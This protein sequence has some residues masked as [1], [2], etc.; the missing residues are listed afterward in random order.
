MIIWLIGMSGAGKTTIGQILYQKI[1]TEH[2]NT[3]FLDGD[4]LRDVWGDHLG[5]DMEGRRK[6]AER[7]T[8]LCLMLDRQ[9]IH[10]VAAIL[11]IFPEERRKNRDIFS[12]YFEVFIDTPMEELVRRD[13]KRL[14]AR[15]AAG[16]I[17]D[18]VGFDIPMPRTETWDMII[19]APAVLED[20]HVIAAKIKE[21]L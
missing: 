14:Y 4:M 16:E 20:P 15:A 9:G 19:S 1:K 21:R 13:S 7:F 6:N 12:R 2:P 17:K 18:V 11:S 8:R 10:V 3:V 5:H